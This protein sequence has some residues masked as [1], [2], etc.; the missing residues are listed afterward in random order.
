MTAQ[1][2]EFLIHRG[3][4]HLMACDPL[5]D[6]LKRWPKAKRPK[7]TVWSTGNYRGYIGTWEIRNN[8][9]YLIDITSEGELY[10]PSGGTTKTSM[11]TMF[12]KL[13]EGVLRADWFSDEIR[14]PEGGMTC[15]RHA[16]YGSEYERDRIFSFHKGE[17]IGET[18]IFNPPGALQYQVRP[19]GSLE[20]VQADQFH[21]RIP[22][23]LASG[24]YADVYKY[25]GTRPDMWDFEEYPIPV[26]QDLADD[27]PSPIPL[28]GL[29]VYRRSL[30]NPASNEAETSSPIPE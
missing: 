23:P 30:K 8:F 12:P 19:D 2:Y 9:L 25:W 1:A 21:P 16:G 14:C 10:L 6:Y 22:D 26:T 24:N 17:L 18:L 15:Y 5:Y 20:W 11:A 29:A 13:K 27:A 4:R 28:H 3:M 7:F